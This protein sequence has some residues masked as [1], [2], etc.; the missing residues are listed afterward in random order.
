LALPA[1]EEISAATVVD[2]DGDIRSGSS[3]EGRIDGR[4]A[5][6]ELGQKILSGGQLR[7]LAAWRCT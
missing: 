3:A 4:A 5:T 7:D 2:V 6:I 1:V